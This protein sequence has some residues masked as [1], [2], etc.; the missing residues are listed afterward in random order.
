MENNLIVIKQLPVIEDQLVAVKKSIEE[1]VQTAL[2]LVCTEDTYKDIKKVRSDLNKEYQE[3]EKRRKEVK[4]QILK[5]YE[6]FEGIYK[7]CAGDLYASADA[8]LKARI[9]EVEDGLKTQKAEELTRYFAEKRTALGID[10]SFVGLDAAGIRV[11]L[12][13]SM[14]AL[15]N[16]VDDFLGQISSDLQ[17]IGTLEHQDE[18]LTEYRNSYNLSGAML[19]VENRHRLIEAEK[20]RREALEA[21]RARLEAERKAREE[22]EKAAA[23]AA[24]AEEAAWKS[25]A[26]TPADAPAPVNPP[27]P[28]DPK[29]VQ[30]HTVILRIT[31]TIDG[32]NQLKDF[33]TANHIAFERVK[34]E[35]K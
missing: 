13:D 10:E 2:S 28:A 34:G 7:E 15:K 8:Q 32:M 16:K 4:A 24:E 6:A 1:R 17:V 11:G 14:T 23:E 31:T 18:V 30:M 35:S 5:P 12:S 3:L 27:A 26:N 29:A 33:M 20:A 21:E 22:S 19:T 9:T 25:L